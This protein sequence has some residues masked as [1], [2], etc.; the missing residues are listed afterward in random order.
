M[1]PDQGFLKAKTFLQEQF[2]NEQKV[3]FINMDKDLSWSP[4]KM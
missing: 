2:W 1:N 4:I 3:D